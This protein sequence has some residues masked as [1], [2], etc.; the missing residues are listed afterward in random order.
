[1][2]IREAQERAYAI[3][4]SKGWH[5]EPRSFGDLMALA[6]SEL[7]EALESYRSDGMRCS[8]RQDGKPEGVAPELADVV[9]RV[10]DTCA[11]LGIDLESEVERKMAY[12]AGRG[13]RH[14]G[15]RL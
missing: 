15:K 8:I 3:A 14:G 10:M 5:D 2:R 12:N 6:H 4:K 13:H 1:M 7:S 9:I 11:Y